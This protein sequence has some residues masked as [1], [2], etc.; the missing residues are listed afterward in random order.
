MNFDKK[1]SSQIYNEFYNDYKKNIYPIAKKYL[2]KCK[3][4]PFLFKIAFPLINIAPLF[5]IALI[6]GTPCAMIVTFVTNN[7]SP[8]AIF[9]GLTLFAV[10]I[11]SPFITLITNSYREL[12]KNLSDIVLPYL[13]KIIGKVEYF[14]S[15]VK[16]AVFEDKKL[17]DLANVLPVHIRTISLLNEWKYSG[18]LAYDRLDIEYK[19]ILI[20]IYEHASN[21]VI[22]INLKKNFSGHTLIQKKGPRFIKTMLKKTKFEDIVFE[23]LYN[24]YTDDEIESRYI[25]SPKML[26]QIDI[27]HTVTKEYPEAIS[28]YQNQ[29]YIALPRIHDWFSFTCF[30]KYKCC[31]FEDIFAIINLTDFLINNFK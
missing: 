3:L 21:V 31:F 27:L 20:R 24:A 17:L 18:L 6:L 5:L 14:E 19:N 11:V 25:L 10:L 23:K 29:V 26:E 30:N 15:D 2:F 12:N 8:M 9:F 22:I 28:F 13:K 16:T 4:I 1:N 7:P